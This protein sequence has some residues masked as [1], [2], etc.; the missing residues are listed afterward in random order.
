MSVLDQMRSLFLT[1]GRPRNVSRFRKY[2]LY[3]AHTGQ[4]VAKFN[5]RAEAEATKSSR[6]DHALRVRGVPPKQ[7]KRGKRKTAAR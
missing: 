1:D 4:L 6:G 2:G 3:H 5:T 7:K